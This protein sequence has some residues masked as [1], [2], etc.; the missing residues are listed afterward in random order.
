M[1]LQV[2]A[3]PIG[4]QGDNRARKDGQPQPAVPRPEYRSETNP[5]GGIPPYASNGPQGEAWEA[6]KDGKLRPI[7]ERMKAK[8]ESEG[9]DRQQ[10]EKRYDR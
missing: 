9:G 1:E 6:F 4:R 10:Q 7:A 8:R 3:V 5:E 2:T